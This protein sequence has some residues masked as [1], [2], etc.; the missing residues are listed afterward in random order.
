MKYSYVRCNTRAF[1]NNPRVIFEICRGT[2]EDT[3]FFVNLVES[4]TVGQ[5]H[6][7]RVYTVVLGLQ[8]IYMP[9]CTQTRF[10]VYVPDMHACFCHTS[11]AYTSTLHRSF[12]VIDLASTCIPACMQNE[13][14]VVLSTCHTRA[15]ST[16]N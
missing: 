9:R 5:E 15:L 10:G 14:G 8:F 16:L 12:Y 3:R 11:S 7:H 2:P 13:K 4:C 1:E 6:V